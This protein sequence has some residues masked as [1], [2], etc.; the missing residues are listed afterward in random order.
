MLPKRA[1]RSRLLP[2]A[3]DSELELA[4][5]RNLWDYYWH[6][7]SPPTISEVYLDLSIRLK[8]LAH[9][10]TDINF[11]K[12]RT[13]LAPLIFKIWNDWETTSGLARL[14][15]TLNRRSK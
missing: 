9:S 4:F 15:S 6:D 5:G 8:N 10:V 14:I 2:S 11:R 7:R 12:A 13:E 3:S 1:W